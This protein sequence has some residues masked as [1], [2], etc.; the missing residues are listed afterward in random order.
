M[1]AICNPLRILVSLGFE[2]VTVYSKTK[3]I[4]LCYYVAM[5][6]PKEIVSGSHPCPFYICARKCL[7]R[8]VLDSKQIKRN[9]Q[10]R[11]IQEG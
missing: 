4:K 3:W 10:S 7:R 11:H 6:Q 5:M 8:A 9:L 1:G 2:S